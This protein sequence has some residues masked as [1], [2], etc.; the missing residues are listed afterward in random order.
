MRERL[1][2][3]IAATNS[4][5]ENSYQEAGSA[6]RVLLV[7]FKND[8]LKPLTGKSLAEIAAMRGTS[9][10]ETALDM[11]VEDNSRVGTIF[12]TMS[13]ENVRKKITL[14]WVSFCSDS[15]TLAPEGVFLKSNPAP[16]RL[17]QLRPPLGQICP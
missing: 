15:A 11:V 4:G 12:F 3:E 16:A 13:E 7:S 9:P 8:A 10:I 5:W 1:V 6:E 17:W 2:R 14:P